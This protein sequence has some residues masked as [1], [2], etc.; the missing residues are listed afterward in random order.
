M[1]GGWVWGPAWRR[2][3]RFLTGKRENDV[4]ISE[5]VRVVCHSYG[6]RQWAPYCPRAQE[7]GGSGGRGWRVRAGPSTGHMFHGNDLPVGRYPQ[8]PRSFQ[9]GVRT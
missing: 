9:L 8:D 2:L 5:P 3:D 7:A 4:V 6:W 1:E